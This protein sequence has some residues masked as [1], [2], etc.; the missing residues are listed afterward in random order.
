MVKFRT[1]TAGALG[2][3]SGWGTRILQAAKHGK[4]KKSIWLTLCGKH[5]EFFVSLIEDLGKVISQL[6]LSTVQD[7]PDI[8]ILGISEHY[9]A[10]RDVKDEVQPFSLQMRNLFDQGHLSSPWL[11]PD[12][13]LY[14]LF[15][16]AA[17]WLS[18]RQPWKDLWSILG[19]APEPGS[20]KLQLKLTTRWLWGQVL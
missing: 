17:L 2:S 14:L 10:R 15:I 12:Q 7:S 20:W 19:L 3:V 4:K 16:I 6:R 5:S 13:T 9:R 1:V 8:P 11:K 18:V